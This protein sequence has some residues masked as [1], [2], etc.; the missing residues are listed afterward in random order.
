[1]SL[2]E[3]FEFLLYYKWLKDFSRTSTSSAAGPPSECGEN[4]KPS[5]SVEGF[6]P[7]FC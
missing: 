5:T 4:P 3:K 6:S 2:K 1:M 7:L